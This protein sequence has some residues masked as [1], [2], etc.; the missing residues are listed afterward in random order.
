MSLAPLVGV[1]NYNNNCNNQSASFLPVELNLVIGKYDSLVKYVHTCIMLV[2]QIILMHM[3]SY[4][5]YCVVESSV[6]DD[7]M[8]KLKF[9][10]IDESAKFTNTIH[11]CLYYHPQAFKELR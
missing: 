5:Y 6:A 2:V 1:F 9:A 11:A 10:D 7:L 8:K 3:L 4:Y